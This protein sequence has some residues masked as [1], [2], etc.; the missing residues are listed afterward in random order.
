M[1]VIAWLIF[2][3]VAGLLAQLLFPGDQPGGNN[4]VGLIVTI[5]IG[6]AGAAVGGF[7]GALLG[8]GGVDD[9]DIGSMVTAVLG[10]IAVLWAWHWFMG[11]MRGPRYSPR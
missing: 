10:A 1:G 7:I 2:G 4:L 3:G 9:F 5:L 8:F 11:R 6:L